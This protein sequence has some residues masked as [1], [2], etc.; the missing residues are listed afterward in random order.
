[1]EQE[2]FIELLK[3]SLFEEVRDID[4][5]TALSELD[6]W[7]SLGRLRVGLLFHE[8]LGIVIDTKTMMKCVTIGDL[9]DLAKERVKAPAGTR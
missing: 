2:A 3:E 6:G 8:Q 4:R 5:D 9:V 7:D 1:M